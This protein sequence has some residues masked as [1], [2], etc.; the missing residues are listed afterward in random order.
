MVNYLV[1]GTFPDDWNEQRQK[2]MLET[3]KVYFWD[4][5]YLFRYCPDQIIRRCI[6]DNEQQ[7]DK[8]TTKSANAVCMWGFE[9]LEQH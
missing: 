8:V 7:S 2:R 1:T 3:V 6:P 5:P 9:P 4:D